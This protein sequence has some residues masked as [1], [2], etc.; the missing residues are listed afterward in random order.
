MGY[1]QE[2]YC[3]RMIEFDPAKKQIL[4]SKQR[5]NYNSGY[6]KI[7]ILFH[8]FDESIKPITVNSGAEQNVQECK[9]K[10]LDGLDNL[11][12]IY[13][14]NYYQGLKAAEQMANQKRI[15]IDNKITEITVQW[16]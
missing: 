2:D 14:S 9:I 7:Q 15:T 11:A 1:K 13:D 6:K 3:K 8:G 5:G 12:I 10:I 16:E 4:F